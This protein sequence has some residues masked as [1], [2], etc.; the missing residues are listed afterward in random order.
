M[1]NI[2][3]A[4]RLR[5]SMLKDMDIK[6]VDLGGGISLDLD[7]HYR[8]YR[9]EEESYSSFYDKSEESDTS[10]HTPKFTW[11]AKMMI[12]CFLSLLIVF[13]CLI[14][15]LVFPEQ[16]LSNSYIQ[17]LKT[18]YQ[19][20]Y[21]KEEVLNNIE[22]LTSMTYH[23]FEYIIPG[24]LANKVKDTYFATIKPKVMGF[25]L[26]ETMNQYV[27]NKPQ[28]VATPIEEKQPEAQQEVKDKEALDGVGGGEPIEE[29]PKTPEES[30]AVSMMQDDVGQIVNK[31]INMIKPISGV[32]TSAYGARDQ[33]FDGVNSY[34]TGMDIA[35]NMGTQ[36]HSATTGKVVKVQKMDKYYGNYVVVETDGV[37]F[38]YAHMSEIKATLGDEIKQ[39]DIVGLVGSTGM[40]TGP[41]LHF[42]ISINGRT[43]DP[44]QLIKF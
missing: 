4:R 34:H 44:Q 1:E 29:T 13:V 28:A 36:I 31:N 37:N 39:N 18:E 15:K 33:I 6:N 19:K 35:N 42:E 2:V 25:E 24:S 16:F 43:V 30:S 40:S 20:D 26:K 12:K 11:K 3:S 8:K 14:G 22:K 9:G 23:N 10:L 21:G 17:M 7:K 5:K 27:F 38:K 41:H 32:I